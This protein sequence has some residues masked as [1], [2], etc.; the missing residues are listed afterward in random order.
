M[1]QKGLILYY[2]VKNPK[3][4]CVMMEKLLLPLCAAAGILVVGCSDPSDGGSDIRIAPSITRVDGVNFT[5]GDRIGVTVSLSS[6]DLPP[7]G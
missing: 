4:F 1:T 3:T 6:G 2:K 7:T 5:E